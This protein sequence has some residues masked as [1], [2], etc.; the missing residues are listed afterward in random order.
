MEIRVA[1]CSSADPPSPF[2]F[3]PS[4]PIPHS[5]NPIVP[6]SLIPRRRPLKRNKRVAH[7]REVSYDMQ[8]IC[9]TF[10]RPL[11]GQEQETAV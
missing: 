10:S 5:P 4:P 8:R 2:F 9:C 7:L 3:L 1:R 11:T 6:Q